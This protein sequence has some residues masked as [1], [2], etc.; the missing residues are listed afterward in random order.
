MYAHPVTFM[1]CRQ[2]SIFKPIACLTWFLKIA[3]VR[4]VGIYMFVCACVYARVRVHVC[5][6]PRL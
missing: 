6:P 1:Q 2:F 3:F 4:E 5:L